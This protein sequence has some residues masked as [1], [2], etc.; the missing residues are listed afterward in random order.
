LVTATFQML[1]SL[2]GGPTGVAM[3]ES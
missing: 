1:L 2:L 3:K